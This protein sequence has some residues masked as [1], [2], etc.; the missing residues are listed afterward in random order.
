LE[1]GEYLKVLF[2]TSVLIDILKGKKEAV[3]KVEE[4][5]EKSEFYTS[6]INVYE[7]LR[8]IMVIKSKSDQKI[9]MAAM[10][11]LLTSIHILDFDIAASEKSSIIYSELRQKGIKIDEDD[12]LIAGICISNGIDMLITRDRHFESVTQ[13]KSV[14]Y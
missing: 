9:H 5:K 11:T 1:A 4:L 8:G 12:Y 10:D 14:R 13:L 2:D 7:I 3:S 6:S